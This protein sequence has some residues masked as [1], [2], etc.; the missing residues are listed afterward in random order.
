MSD[1]PPALLVALP[2]SEQI[3]ALVKEILPDTPWAYLDLN[4]PADWRSVRAMLVEDLRHE[5]ASFDSRT[6]P[7]LQFVQEIWTGLDRFP[8]ERFPASVAV[9]GNVGGFAP[10]VAE[11]AIALALSAARDFHTAQVMIGAGRLRPS[12]HERSLV[13]ATAVV[14][15][16]GV[17]GRAIAERLAPFEARAVGLNRTGTPARGAAE[18]FPASRLTEALRA[19]SFVFDVRPLTRATVATIGKAEL[20]AMQPTAVLVNVGRAGTVDQTALYEHLRTHPEFR[21][22]FDVWW[23]ED[24][25][26]GTITSHHPFAR[27]PNFYG[28]PHCADAFAAA[29]RRALHM[30]L[31]NLARFFR[32]GRPQF[33]ADMAEYKGISQREDSLG[34]TPG[35]PGS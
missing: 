33:V 22:A 23:E 25:V 15:G 30:A 8:F 29:K 35:E 24:H 16:Y 14:L 27:L 18:M 17:I 34:P 13:G 21:A 19:G 4:R 28:T 26:R 1:T 12:P 20:A 9:A 32:D 2:K 6:T 31:D 5:F 10:Y 7:G 11:H 3:D